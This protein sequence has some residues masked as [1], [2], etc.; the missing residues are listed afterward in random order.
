MFYLVLPGLIIFGCLIPLSLF[1]LMYL[2]RNGLDVY[3]LRPHICYL[4]NEYVTKRY[5][6]EEIKLSN[7]A[8]II[9]FLTYFETNIHL[10]ASLIGLSLICYQQFAAKKK[11]YIISKFNML[12][13]ESG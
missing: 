10:K 5:Y 7:K 2:K 3:T 8:L 1:S 6:W 4:F 11:P 13:L 12:D 9:L